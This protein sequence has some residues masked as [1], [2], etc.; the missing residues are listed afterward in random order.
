MK[1]DAKRYYPNKEERAKLAQNHTKEM[2]DL[3]RAKISE[4]VTFFHR[5]TTLKPDKYLGWDIDQVNE[6]WETSL[7]KAN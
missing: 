7:F 3:L 6:N 1:Y 4:G 5:Q 2:E